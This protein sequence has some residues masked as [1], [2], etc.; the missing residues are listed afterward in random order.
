MGALKIFVEVFGVGAMHLNKLRK[1]YFLQ[2]VSVLRTLQ[3]HD[4]E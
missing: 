4:F 3:I 1:D 2:T